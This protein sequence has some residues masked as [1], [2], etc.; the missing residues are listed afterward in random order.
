[1]SFEEI[2]SHFYS[3]CTVNVRSACIFCNAVAKRCNCAKIRL[4]QLRQMEGFLEN[5]ISYDL[6]NK[7]NLYHLMIWLESA[8]KQYEQEKGVYDTPTFGDTDL[9][10]IIQV[11]EG[12]IYFMNRT[13]RGLI[14]IPLDSAIDSIKAT[15]IAADTV[16]TRHP[17]PDW[18]KIPP[19]S[20]CGLCW[21][22]IHDENN[23]L[24][25]NHPSCYCHSDPYL[26][27]ED[28]LDH[29]EQ[30]SVRNVVCVDCPVKF[31]NL[32]ALLK[33]SETHLGT[34]IIIKP[35][36]DSN[37]GLKYCNAG[38]IDGWTFLKHLFLFHL[39]SKETCLALVL[40][41]HNLIKGNYAAVGTCSTRTVAGPDTTPYTP[42]QHST[43]LL[44]TYP[45]PRDGLLSRMPSS[46]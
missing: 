44:Y 45:S 42:A 23:H 19:P 40:E 32:G 18:L 9:H 5:S 35:E 24:A 34:H 43:C 12:K 6:I 3:F 29:F 30:H 10:L 8:A 26:T 21:H 28:L 20:V 31:E 13:S 22:E 38:E 16:G 41:S 11:G 7:A 15:G 46:A 36:C 25:A 2:M 1:M 37:L 39:D 4:P 14:N 33:H 17:A 27:T